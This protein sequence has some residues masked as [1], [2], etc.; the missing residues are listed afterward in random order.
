M[1]DLDRITGDEVID[2]S[3]GPLAALVAF[4]RGFNGRD[5]AAVHDNW[6]HEEA[7]VMSNPLGGVR[8]GWRDIAE[9]YTRL[10]HGPA[11]VHVEF[12][13]YASQISEDMFC[14]AG[15]ESGWLRKDGEEITLAIR[16]SRIY[17][18]IDGQWKQVHHHGS[19]DQ[20]ELLAR[21]QRAV[22]G[23]ELKVPNP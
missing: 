1:Q 16:T 11:E 22:L 3:A 14:V 4:Y 12:H 6:A 5:L 13:D 21:Y 17:R 8:R 9:V 20:P 23:G 18:R 7:V 19:M 10:F 2:D 15:R